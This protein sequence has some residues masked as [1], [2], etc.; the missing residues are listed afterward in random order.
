MKNTKINYLAG[1][2]I[3]LLLF[4][5]ACKKEPMPYKPEPSAFTVEPKGTLAALPAAGGKLDVVVNANSNGWWIVLP[6]ESKA[7]CKP[8][9]LFGSGNQTIAIT[10]SPNTTNVARKTELIINPTFNLEP[11]KLVIEQ[12]P[13]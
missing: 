8:S 7:W 5:T 10:L 4:I 2:T 3:L 9:K 13:N 6:E 11:V 1:L 12:L